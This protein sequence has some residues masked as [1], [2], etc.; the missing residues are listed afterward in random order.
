MARKIDRALGAFCVAFSAFFIVA[1]P[2]LTG[3]DT[4]SLGR[5]A[6]GITLFLALLAAIPGVYLLWRGRSV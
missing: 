4:T 5:L 2:S 1:G 3:Q 6:G